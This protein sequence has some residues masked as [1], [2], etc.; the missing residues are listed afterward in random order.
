MVCLTTLPL[1]V[2]P[3]QQCRIE[4]TTFYL[5]K[6]LSNNTTLQSN[7]TRKNKA[8]NYTNAEYENSSSR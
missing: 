1:T 3:E 5:L 6:I 7:Y 4:A 8:D 2:S